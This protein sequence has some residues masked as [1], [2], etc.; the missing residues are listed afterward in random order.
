[1]S[2]SI[3]LFAQPV[4]AGSG[5]SSWVMLSSIVS[6]PLLGLL[7]QKVHH[8]VRSGLVVLDKVSYLGLYDI[9]AADFSKAECVSDDFLCIQVVKG[10][11]LNYEGKVIS[12]C[13][14][15]LSITPSYLGC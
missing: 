7:E 1:M 9:E 2:L 13:F 14:H 10:F 11:Y 5:I 12:E 15:T 4:Q 6:V 8:S 3:S